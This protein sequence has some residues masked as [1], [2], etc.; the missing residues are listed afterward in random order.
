MRG[1]GDRGP[2]LQ[3]SDLWQLRQ[4]LNALHHD[5]EATVSAPPQQHLAQLR[6]KSTQWRTNCGERDVAN[7][8]LQKKK[9]GRGSPSR[10]DTKEWTAYQGLIH[11]FGHIDTGCDTFS[12][13]SN[14]GSFMQKG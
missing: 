1:G 9:D 5:G 4:M 11:A 10:K 3:F 2:V 7:Q 14:M 13:S 8:K 12:E 6:E